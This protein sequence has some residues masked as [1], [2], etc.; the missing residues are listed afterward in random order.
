M[1]PSWQMLCTLLRCLICPCIGP[2][3]Y[4]GLYEA[5]CLSVGAGGVGFGTDMLEAELCT[6]GGEPFA[7]DQL[8]LN[9]HS[10]GC[11]FGPSIEF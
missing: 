1:G 10:Y 3:T 7:L 9:G 8:A 5:L 2:F 4:G 6:G 11:S